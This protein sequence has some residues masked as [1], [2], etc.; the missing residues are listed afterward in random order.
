MRHLL[1]GTVLI[2]L[3]ILG[4]SVWWE[5]FGLVMRALVP[6]AL[7]FVGVLAVLSGYHRLGSSGPG[8]ESEQEE[9]VED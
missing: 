4:L 8:S 6:L 9:L 1:I 3:G 5:S 2:A 7:L